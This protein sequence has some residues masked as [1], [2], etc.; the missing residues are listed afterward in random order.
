MASPVLQIRVPE[1]LLEAFKRTAAEQEQDTSV[2]LR[3]AI[4]RYVAQYGGVEL[5]PPDDPQPPK[6][7]KVR[8]PEG[9]APR[10]ATPRPKGG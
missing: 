10:E 3:R 2:L 8:P 9:D 6:L 4:W 5:P 7:G 1:E